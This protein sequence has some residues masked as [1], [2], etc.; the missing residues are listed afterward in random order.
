MDGIARRTVAA[1]RL[2]DSRDA[3]DMTS[4]QKLRGYGEHADA[5]QTVRPHSAA[6]SSAANSRDGASDVREQGRRRRAAAD[7]QTHPSP[8]K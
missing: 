7:T 2:H 6:H 5:E 8:S 1:A 4:E 3:K